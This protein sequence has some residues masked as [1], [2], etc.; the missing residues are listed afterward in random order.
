ML[1]ILAA[2]ILILCLL[3]AIMRHVGRKKQLTSESTVLITGGCL[4]LGRE[5]ALLFASKH[6]CNVIVYDIRDD[7]A[8]GVVKDIQ[9]AGGKGHF[10]KCDI[11]NKQI[12]AD[13]FTD[14]IKKFG[15][16]DILINNAG[17]VIS[18]TFDNHTDEEVE[19]VMRVNL[20]GPYYLAKQ[21]LPVMKKR[22]A[23]HIVTIASIV[24]HTYSPDASLYTASKGAL[25]NM[26]S[27]LRLELKRE[28]SPIKT[29]LVCPWAIDTGMFDGFKPTYTFFGLLDFLKVKDVADKSY[30]G[31]MHEREEIYIPFYQ[32]I[33][34]RILHTI[35]AKISDPI[36][37]WLTKDAFRNLVGRTKKDN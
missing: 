23:G 16:I 33:A 17:I 27:S 8:D 28:N 22:N 11:S 9:T 15:H 2:S 19:K 26:F 25:F 32:Q 30:E 20:W 36:A 5:L 3:P 24:S 12:V 34:F 13:I 18:K 29:T 21:V 31:I 7:L 1:I 6:Q 35:P 10:Y 14:T 4:G 37:L